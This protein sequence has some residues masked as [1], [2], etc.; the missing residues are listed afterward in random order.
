MNRTA[1]GKIQAHAL[2]NL[3]FILRSIKT[4]IKGHFKEHTYYKMMSHVYR[5]KLQTWVEQKS[6]ISPIYFQEKKSNKRF[7][8][9]KK[10]AV[11]MTD[12]CGEC[13]VEELLKCCS[14]SW[15]HDVEQASMETSRWTSRI[16]EVTAN[17]C[18]WVGSAILASLK[19]QNCIHYTPS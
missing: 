2:F 18:S 4:P 15:V 14:W 12:H 9:K 17:I 16:Q 5:E 19:S 6:Y 10:K 1:Q 11:G 13:W 7:K 8:K 3:F